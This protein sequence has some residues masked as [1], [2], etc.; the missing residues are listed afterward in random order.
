MKFTDPLELS[1]Y[2]SPQEQ[3]S[4]SAMLCPLHQVSF[5]T[6]ISFKNWSLRNSFH[7]NKV[8]NTHAQIELELSSQ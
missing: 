4:Y 5:D 6:F 1:L 2:Y 7:E 8:T 3:Y